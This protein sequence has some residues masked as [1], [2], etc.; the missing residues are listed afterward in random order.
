[1]GAPIRIDFGTQSN[2]GRYGPDTGPRHINAYVEQVVEGQPNYPIYA[3]P[4]MDEFATI[5]SGGKCRGLIS[6]DSN[7]FALSGTKFVS[8]NQARVM[9]DIGGI[10]GSD[11]V[12][13]ARNAAD[14]QQIAIV[15][16]GIRYI[17]SG[18]TLATLSDTDLPPPVGVTFADQRLIYPIADGRLFW[19]DI[20]AA[21]SVDALSFA[22]A[23]GAPDG[24]VGAFAHRL[25]IWLPGTRTT[26]IWRS[27]ANADD[28]FQR[29]SGG[30]IP[31]GC[32]SPH[33]MKAV[34]EIIFW[35]NDKD[36]VVAASGYV[37]QVVSN[38]AVSRDIA[39]VINKKKIV[40]FVYYSGGCGFYVLTCD[41]WTWQLNTTTMKWFERESSQMTNWRG[42]HAAPF[43]N[44]WVIGD[45]SENILHLSDQG[46]FDES[47][48]PL[49]WTV[50]SSPMHA[51]PN[52]VCVDRL[53]LDFVTGVGINSTDAHSSDP[54][55]G[56]R[57]SD[58]G[59]RSWS[60]Q[61]TKSLGADG[62]HETRVTFDGL[63]CTGRQG[64]IWEL[65]ISAPVARG[66]LYAAIEGDAI[67]T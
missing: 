28:P 65:Q 49:V 16:E 60:M 29:I 23:E 6:T 1:M 10:A 51:Y 41:D 25:D 39:A 35:V 46:A 11:D 42:R 58:D 26:E 67:G 24:L 43:G 21:D 56:M 50:R 4:G 40:A 63:G 59:G 38:S 57:Y 37:P 15:A 55:V 62:R 19:S 34:G 2:A 20:D 53:H 44:D 22:T 64:R 18:G 14:T 5:A 31:H 3:A 36:Q 17:Y 61:L 33:S 66:L 30:F 7:L 27:T 48:Q 47:G 32:P 12:F 54:Q 52:R 9:T 8:F 13:M 45:S